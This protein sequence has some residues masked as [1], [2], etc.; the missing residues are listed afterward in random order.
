MTADNLANISGGNVQGFIQE[1]HGTVT[2]YFISQVSELITGKAP[3][4]EQPFTQVEYRQRKS[5]TQ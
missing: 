3:D 5:F 2:Q 1:T 4:T